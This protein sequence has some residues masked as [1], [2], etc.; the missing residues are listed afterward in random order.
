MITRGKLRNIK[1]HKIE[2]REWENTTIRTLGNS[3][4]GQ[5]ELRGGECGE[6]EKTT[7][8]EDDEEEEEEEEE[9]KAKKTEKTIDEEEEEEVNA[10]KTEKTTEEEEE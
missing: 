9:V 7:E 10:A 3:Y 8:E 4:S 2:L 6:D 5:L 1:N